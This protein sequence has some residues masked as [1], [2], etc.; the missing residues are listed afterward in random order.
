MQRSIL[1]DNLAT[2]YVS[3]KQTSSRSRRSP[4][5]GL[6]PSRGSICSSAAWTLAASFAAWLRQKCWLTSCTAGCSMVRRHSLDI[7]SSPL[8]LRS[9]Q[10]HTAWSFVFAV[11]GALTVF[12]KVYSFLIMFLQTFV[13]S[14]KSVRVFIY[15]K[16]SEF[17]TLSTAKE[18]G[19]ASWG[20]CRYGHPM[21]LYCP[22]LNTPTSHHWGYRRDWAG[23]RSPARESWFWRGPGLS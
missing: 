9:A 6:S 22:S 16:G 4:T 14:G 8:N 20:I 2:H 5:V 12:L 1:D 18:M 7:R 13:L 21:I 17:D 19:G 11:V 3:Q 15:R 10:E 23:V